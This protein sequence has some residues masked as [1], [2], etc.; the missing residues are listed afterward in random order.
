[1][2][3]VLMGGVLMG[4]TGRRVPQKDIAGGG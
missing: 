3:D 1:M 4:Q 2:D